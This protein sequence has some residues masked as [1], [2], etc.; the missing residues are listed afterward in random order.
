MSIRGTDERVFNC[1]WWV[2][3]SG[4]QTGVSFYL[5]QWVCFH[6]GLISVS[7]GGTLSLCVTCGHVFRKNVYN[8]CLYKDECF[9]NWCVFDWKQLIGALI[10][11]S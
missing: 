6:K 1:N 8:V 7:L 2:C 4:G 5:S 9:V 3:L 10:G 11:V